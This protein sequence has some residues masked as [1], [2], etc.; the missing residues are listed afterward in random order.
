[1]IAPRIQHPPESGPTTRAIL[2]WADGRIW[3]TFLM[4]DQTALSLSS[5]GTL[6]FFV[7]TGDVKRDGTAIW[8]ECPPSPDTSRRPPR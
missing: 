2:L 7:P 5:G 4:N 6:H 3:D 8:V 1:M